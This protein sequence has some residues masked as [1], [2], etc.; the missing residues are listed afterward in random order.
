MQNLTKHNLT[1][2]FQKKQTLTAIALVLMLTMTTLMANMPSANAAVTEWD[3]NLFVMLAPNPV[4]VGQTM[5]VTFQMDKVN[6]LAAGLAGGEHFKGF[7]VKITKPDGT[8]ETKGPYEAWAPSGAFFYFTPTAEGKY[9]FQ[10]FFAGQWANST[11]YQRWYK[12][13][14]SAIVELTVQQDPIPGYP[15]VP[16]PTDYWTRPIY[17]ENKGWNTIADNWL[18]TSYDRPDALW[19]GAATFAPYT[20]APNSAHILWTKPIQ[21]GGI[22]GGKFGDAVYYTG[23]SYEQNYQPLIL[24]GRIIYTNHQPAT[25]SPAFGTQCLDLYTGEEIWYLNNTN[26]AFAQTMAF[27]SGNEHGMLSYLWSTSGTSANNTWLAYD[28]FTGRQVLTVTNITAGTTRFGPNGELLS[29]TLN[30][31]NNWLCM[32]NSTKAIFGAAGVS[33]DYWSPPYGAVIDGRRGIEWNVSIPDVPGSQSILMIGE[34]YLLARYADT[35]VYPNLYE[36]MGYD[37]GSIKAGTT[38]INQLWI[39]NRTDIWH[40][41]PK[42]SQISDGVY[43]FYSQ[44]KLQF[45]GYDIKTGKELWVTDPISTNG[46]AYFTYTYYMA[47]GNL[48]ACGYDGVVYCF[49][50]K[51]GKL[52]WSY[53]AGNAGTETPYG[54]WPFYEGMVI[55]DGKVYAVNTE[56]S[57]DS[58]MWRGGK[59]HVIDA[60][61]GEGLWNISG[62]LKN[63]AISD[64][65]ATAVNGLDL[66]IYTLGKGPSAT[67]VTASP[68]VSVHGNSVLIEGTVTDQ[69]PGQKGTP[70]ISDVSMG[71]WMEYLHMQKPIP[72][73]ATGVTATLTAIDP[74]GNTQEIGN[75]TS[76]MYGN[77]GMPW[78]P[79]VPGLYQIIANFA[80]TNSYGSS[81]ASTYLTVGPAAAT[82]APTSTPTSTPTAPTATPTPTASPSPAPQP[83]AGPSTD[84]YIIAAAAVVIIAVVA[85]AAV[86]LRK[87][88]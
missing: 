15:G 72:T 13:S 66:Q 22:V 62:W 18:M 37:I 23:I 35:S 81:S 64:G 55:A 85:V 7:T 43:V 24:S 16:L 36:E 44:D 41:S 59:L 6:P 84:M 73:N 20:S 26:I 83:E 42:I 34:G 57:P 28:A 63:P 80:G 54:T 53:Y 77:F 40:S 61:T 30:G 4:G 58:V 3:T 25:L 51:T 79:P 45:H 33:I 46:W 12:P 71:A 17:G 78:T 50:G 38:S 60:Y 21:F 47:Y 1:N 31:A 88:K 56:H 10:A 70:A 11:T 14:T 52:I 74:N 68:K 29:Y 39:V 86:I 82:P 87:R 69:S 48:Y 2:K 9:T 27:D 8:T 65:I 32:W 67:T 76:D 5:E 75:A 49:N 19:R